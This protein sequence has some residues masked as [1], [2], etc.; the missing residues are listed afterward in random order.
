MSLYNY[1]VVTP[2]QTM[3][4]LRQN[5]VLQIAQKSFQHSKNTMLASNTIIMTL[6]LQLIIFFHAPWSIATTLLTIFKC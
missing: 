4:I 5:A 3:P 1:N 2:I 6:L